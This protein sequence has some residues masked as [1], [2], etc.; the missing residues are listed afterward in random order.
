MFAAATR[1]NIVGRGPCRVNKLYIALVG[2]MSLAACAQ[3][4]DPPQVF[5]EIFANGVSTEVTSAGFGGLRDV[6]ELDEAASGLRLPARV[7][8]T[9]GMCTPAAGMSLPSWWQVRTNNLLAAYPGSQMVQDSLET[10]ALPYGSRLTKEI[11][12]SPG[13]AGTI[14]LWFLDW[15]PLTVPYKPTGARDPENP[16]SNPYRYA[17]A[18][19]NSTLKQGLVK[20]CLADVV[21]YLGKNGEPIRRDTQYA[22]CEFFGGRMDSRTGCA[23]TSA[24]RA[25]MLVSESL[26][27]SIL[28]DGFRSLRFDYMP[29]PQP[30]APQQAPRQT[31]TQRRL[32]AATGPSIVGRDSATSQAESNSHDITLAM[33]SLTNFFMLANQIPLIGL[34]NS[35]APGDLERNR[36]LDEFIA[37]ASETR[38]TG[39]KPLTIVAFVD[40][41]D[42]LSFRL[43]PKS[44]RA[45]IVNFVVSN[46]DTYLGYAE[47]PDEA[48]CNYIRNAYVMHAIVFG[49]AGGVPQRGAV[50]DSEPCLEVPPSGRGGPAH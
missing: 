18:T 36:S 17:K 9:H 22:L 29:T 30:V 40:P 38:A 19:L 20:D 31:K 5:D 49:Y 14:E 12:T 13:A 25:T 35:P 33:T 50:D 26:G 8:W 27:S 7:L 48:H 44:D 10:E 6:V 16:S 41:N 43:L 4:Y 15:S 32:H 45:R 39:T 21:I 23:G 24:S 28:F 47:R 3:A 1:G 11:L 37:G 42:L 46:A 34:A 2:A